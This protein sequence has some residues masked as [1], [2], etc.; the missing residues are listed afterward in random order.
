MKVR[1]KMVVILANLVF[2]KGS[3]LFRHLFESSFRRTWPYIIAILLKLRLLIFANYV[4]VRFISFARKK[5]KF[6]LE[7]CRKTEMVFKKKLQNHTMN[8]DYKW[9]HHLRPATPCISDLIVTK[10]MFQKHLKW[11]HLE[12]IYRRIFEVNP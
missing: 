11:F 9:V 4:W 5:Y 6:R 8:A 10:E 3:S 12:D 7:Y 1:V 2:I